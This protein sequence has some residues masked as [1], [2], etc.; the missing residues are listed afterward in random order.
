MSIMKDF[1]E[2]AVKGNMMELAV[3]VII[4]AAFGKIITSLVKY[5]LMPPLAFI[6]GNVSVQDLK[7]YIQ[8]P[9]K[10]FDGQVLHPG[11]VIEY[12]YF[13]QASID[14]IIIAFAVFMIVRTLNKLKKKE[15]KASG[16]S[17]KDILLDIKKEL[18]TL[19]KKK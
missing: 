19:N 4:G 14:F 10:N 15:E 2:F 11:V 12:G 18:V 8:E 7:F 17:E 3:A 9:V 1:K 13:L 16:P 6:T 5:I